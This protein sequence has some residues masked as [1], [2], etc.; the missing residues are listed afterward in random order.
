MK[1]KIRVSNSK[2]GLER[3]PATGDDGVVELLLAPDASLV[4]VPAVVVGRLAGVDVVVVLLLDELPAVPLRSSIL[5]ASM[6]TSLFLVGGGG[7]LA[8]D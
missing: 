4:A 3:P 8:A 7:G 2:T 5:A 1:S 6:T